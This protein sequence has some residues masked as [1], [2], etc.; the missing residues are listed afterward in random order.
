MSLKQVKCPH[1]DRAYKNKAGLASHVYFKHPGLG[2]GEAPRPKPMTPADAPERQAPAPK[3]KA[4]RKWPL[5]KAKPCPHCAYTYKNWNALE[6]HVL[7]AHG[8]YFDRTSVAP[9]KGSKTLT[10]ELCGKNFKFHSWLG[11]HTKKAHPEWHTR[12]DQT[13]SAT[14]SKSHLEL[15]ISEIQDEIQQIDDRQN[16]LYNALDGLL[17]ARS[18]INSRSRDAKKV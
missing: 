10:C 2:V 9:N 12:P 14:T 8:L 16:L 5:K 17:A 7:T 1:C 18:V 15:A 6:A 4:K 11:K 13:K 3:L